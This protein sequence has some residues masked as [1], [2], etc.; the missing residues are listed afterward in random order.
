VGK[1]KTKKKKGIIS[2]AIGK[3]LCFCDKIELK[4]W[5]VFSLSFSLLTSICCCLFGKIYN[6]HVSIVMERTK[7]IYN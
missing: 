5:G 6:G 7:N 4:L 3:M 2:E 1:K